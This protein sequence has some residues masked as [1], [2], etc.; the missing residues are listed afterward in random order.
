MLKKLWKYY[1]LRYDEDSS[2]EIGF[3][4]FVILMKKQ[5]NLILQILSSK[6][7]KDDYNHSDEAVQN[8]RGNVEE[9][10][11]RMNHETFIYVYI[12]KYLL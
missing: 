4:E 1:F 5:V 3:T 6:R 12:F 7:I 2:G 11:N 10:K 8:E 9:I